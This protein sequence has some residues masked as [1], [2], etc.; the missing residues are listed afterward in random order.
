M[1][2]KSIIEHIE[3]LTVRIGTIKLLAIKMLC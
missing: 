3:N 2:D 1:F